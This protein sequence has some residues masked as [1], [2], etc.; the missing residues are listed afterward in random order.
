MAKLT[1]VNSGTNSI[2]LPTEISLKEGKITEAVANQMY[3]YSRSLAV[4]I[5][6]GLSFGNGDSGSWAGN[7]D[8]QYVT[9]EAPT[10]ANVEFLVPHG[11]ERVPSGYEVVRKDRAC[12]IYDSRADAW[13]ETSMYVK[14][15]VASA[16][17]TLRVW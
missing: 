9:A 14:S 7:L 13:S 6:G 17:F 1:R 10:G 15:T 12:D 16:I 4:K 5:N 3:S 2:A 8:A 11:L